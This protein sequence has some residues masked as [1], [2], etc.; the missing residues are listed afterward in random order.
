MR[1]ELAV[2]YA[3]LHARDEVL[4]TDLEDLVHQARVQADAT[5][6]R[7]DMALKTTT[8]AE[9]NDGYAPFVGK[10]QKLCHLVPT[11][12]KSDSVVADT[13]SVTIELLLRG[14]NTVL[15]K[16]ALEFRD[17]IHGLLGLGVRDNAPPQK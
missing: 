17:E 5:T 4:G 16:D 10:A 6:H 7:D 12:G 9:G 2:G 13:M 8:L 3:G 11:F 1:V 15:R 14:R